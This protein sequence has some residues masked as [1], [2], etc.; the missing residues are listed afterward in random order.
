MRVSGYDVPQ[1]KIG[2][3][4]AIRAL[5]GALTDSNKWVAH[6]AERALLRLIRRS[7]AV[8]AGQEV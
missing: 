4:V 5:R 8:V 3:D 1:Q 2:S 7:K 6:S